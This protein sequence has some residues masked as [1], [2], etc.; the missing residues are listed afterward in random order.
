MADYRKELPEVP[1]RLLGL[2]VFRGYP[3]P[4]FVQWFDWLGGP[5]SDLDDHRGVPDFRIMDGRRLV[6]A[7]EERRCWICGGRNGGKGSFVIGPMCAVNRISAEPPSHARCAVFSVKA[8]PFLVRPTM[9]RREAGKVEGTVVAGKMLERNP[10]VSLI[11]TTR[12]FK[13]VSGGSHGVLFRM[14]S[15][16]RIEAY[17]EGRK[18]T[19]Q[20]VWDS[21]KGGLPALREVAEAESDAAVRDLGRDLGRA[22]GLLARHGVMEVHDV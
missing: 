20:E 7:V 15:P 6:Q 17:S 1:D 11:W 21:I 10:G 12:A 16:T 4:W 13:V 19:G 18:A 14:G 5:K 22:V 9:V 2:P 8:C 3:V